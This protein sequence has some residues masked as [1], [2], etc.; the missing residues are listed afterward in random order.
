MNRTE[1]NSDRKRMHNMELL[2]SRNANS[3]YRNKNR[4]NIIQ[5]LVLHQAVAAT[6]TV[7]HVADRFYCEQVLPKFSMMDEA[8]LMPFW[9]KKDSDSEFW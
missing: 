7:L 4:M 9:K 8:I 2:E 6:T 5:S 1:L 3:Q